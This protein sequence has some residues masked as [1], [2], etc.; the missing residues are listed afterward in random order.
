MRDHKEVRIDVLMGDATATFSRSG[1]SKKVVS[2]ILGQQKDPAT[3]KLTVWLDR[4]VHRGKS[5]V[6]INGEKKF[7]LSGAVSTVM[8]EV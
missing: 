2:N 5:E 1:Q 8:V 3:G 6:A 4:V 7:A